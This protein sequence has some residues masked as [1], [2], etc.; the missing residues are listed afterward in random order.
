M[1]RAL[2]FIIALAG[3]TVL[4]PFLVICGVLVRVYDGG[5]ALYRARRVG[6][7][8]K[9]FA[10]LKFRTM[11]IDAD[12]L[13]TGLTSASDSRIT[14]IGRFLR[15]TKCD[16][17]PQLFNVLKGEMSIVGPRPEDP[18]YVQLYSPE[19]RKVLE[20][21]PGIT[22]AASLHYRNESALLSGPDPEGIYTRQ[23]L[24]HKLA[25]ELEYMQTRTF[26]TDLRLVVRTIQSMFM[27]EEAMGGTH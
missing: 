10:L 16:E 22:S 2:E 1:P 14:P 6:R 25:I 8:G 18:R 9:E 26:W 27:N 15:R 24:P 11:V 4:A 19:Q 17:L 13:G 5:S 3:L 20:I 12:K 23:I 21:R 7:G